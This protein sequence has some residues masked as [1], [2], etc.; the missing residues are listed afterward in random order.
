MKNH[1]SKNGATLL[2][3]GAAEGGLSVKPIKDVK[4]SCPDTLT[5]SHCTTISVSLQHGNKPDKKGLRMVHSHLNA[6]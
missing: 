5:A 6:V 1:C 3:T 4:A 2:F